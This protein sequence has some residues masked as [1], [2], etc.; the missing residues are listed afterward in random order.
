M[1]AVL[2]SLDPRKIDLRFQP[3]KGIAAGERGLVARRAERRVPAY[4]I[5][6]QLKI[7]HRRLEVA[8]A[9]L[10]G[11]VAVTFADIQQKKAVIEGDS[12]GFMQAGRRLVFAGPKRIQRFVVPLC[13]DLIV[14]VVQVPLLDPQADI[15]CRDMVKDLQKAVLPHGQGGVPLNI[16]VKPVRLFQKP[17]E[18]AHFFLLGGILPQP[19]VKEGVGPIVSRLQRA[20][21]S[22]EESPLRALPCSLKRRGRILQ[23]KVVL[24]KEVFHIDTSQK[25]SDIYILQ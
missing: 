15:A 9:V 16:P 3:E 11:K 23:R 4:R 19:S 5:P 17:A 13:C 12:L 25:R 7:V 18:G 22:L 10:G 2:V 20:L 1:P 6:H 14:V 21:G 8:A 24:Q